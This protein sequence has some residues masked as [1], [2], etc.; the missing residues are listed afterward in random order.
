[1]ISPRGRC[2]PDYGRDSNVPN[3]TSNVL[4]FRGTE[5]GTP[6]STAITVLYKDSHLPCIKYLLGKYVYKSF[7]MSVR[8]YD[9]PAAAVCTVYIS[10]DV[11]VAPML[12]N[13]QGAA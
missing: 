10:V 3:Q 6:Y 1:M 12:G 2:P 11:L 5:C 4:R 9:D 8:A 7:G 13:M